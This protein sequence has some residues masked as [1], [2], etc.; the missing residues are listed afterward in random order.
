MSNEPKFT[1]GPW[2]IFKSTDGTK[3]IGIG[4]LT[5][6]GVTDSGFGLWRGN[7]DE[8]TANACLIAAAPELYA[9]LVHIE[10][11]WN[12]SET[13]GS[14]S[15]ALYEIVG[16]ACAALAKVRGETS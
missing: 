2:R 15:D 13:E 5:G 12:G 10:E 11:Y 8:A 9:A 16:C 6:E 14:I 7:S 3:I 4:E 1:P